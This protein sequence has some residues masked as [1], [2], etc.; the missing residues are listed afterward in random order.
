MTCPDCEGDGKTMADHV[1][2]ADGK[3]SKPMP[4]T[5]TEVHCR[6]L[7][8]RDLGAVLEIERQTHGASAWTEEDFRKLLVHPQCIGYVAELKYGEGSF[9]P[10]VGYMVHELAPRQ[11]QLAALV[12]APAHRRETVGSQMIRK[13]LTKL[14]PDRRRSLVCTVHER[15]LIAQLFHRAL[16]F[17]CTRIERDGGETYYRMEYRLPN[18]S[19]ETALEVTRNAGTESQ[20]W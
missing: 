19:P 12:V 14:H 8:Q 13:L 9:G 2:Y 10:I 5:T 17:R 15:S 18:C 3:G 16:G 11:I 20:G 6:W 4:V 7:I 1:R